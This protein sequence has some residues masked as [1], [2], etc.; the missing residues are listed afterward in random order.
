MKITDEL[1]DYIGELA[2]L[3]LSG[4][5]R[6]ARKK[7]LTEILDYMDKLN[8]LDTAGLPEMTHPFDASNRFR[9][10]VVLNGDRR[11]EMLGNAPDRKG[12]FFKVFKTVE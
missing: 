4:A 3:E 10:D 6:E 1:I 2:R 9:E 11:Q 12:D 8:E 5:E 7:D